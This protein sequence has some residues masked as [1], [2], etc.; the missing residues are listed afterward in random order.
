MI[1]NSIIFIKSI[2]E[3]FSQSIN[4]VHIFALPSRGPTSRQ[5]KMQTV[6]LFLC[7]VLFFV[8]NSNAYKIEPR[9]YNG[10]T[11]KRGQFP[12]YAFLGI[13]NKGKPLS[14]CGGSLITKEYVLTAAHCVA[15]M[16]VDKSDLIGIHLGS[17]KADD[18]NE[19]GRIVDIVKRKNIYVHPSYNATTLVNDIALI[20]LSRSVELSD[21]IKLIELPESCESNENVE[22][23]IIGNGKM[24]A[25]HNLSPILQYAPIT[26]IDWLK[27]RKIYQFVHPNVLCAASEEGRSVKNGDSGGPLVRKRDGK[28][29]G[30]TSFLQP[31]KFNLTAPQ[32]FV[33]I[34]KHHE[35]IS[36]IT[37]L[38]L[39]KC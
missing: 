10:L 16:G 4:L 36:G 11:S 30:V 17:L 2:K 13:S 1:T 39:I 22:A 15:G 37:K 14:W 33:N 28:L 21:T 29:I 6:Q 38:K 35:F 8:C 19:N 5:R 24:N 9:I 27:C 31:E 32:G 20:K 26:T 12:F 7:L 18:V 3:V 34:I 25:K 23:I